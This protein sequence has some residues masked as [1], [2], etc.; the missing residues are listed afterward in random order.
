MA[1]SSLAGGVDSAVHFMESALGSISHTVSYARIFALNSVHV[2]LSGVFFSLIP[3]IINIPFPPISIAGLEIIPEYF[4]HEGHEIAPHLPLMGAILGTVIVGFLEGMLAFMHTLRLH[5]VE[6][7]SKFFH[8]G[9][10]PYTP[11]KV[12]RL[13]TAA[14][15]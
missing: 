14:P 11:F 13:H 3:G 9:G 12:N 15:N 5:F 2:I 6:W 1:L 4:M 7:F 8:A 10:T